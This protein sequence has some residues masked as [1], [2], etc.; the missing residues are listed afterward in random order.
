MQ[1]TCPA[2]VALIEEPAAYRTHRSQPSPAW[3]GH[4]GW[5]HGSTGAPK[6]SGPKG[7]E[8]GPGRPC[9]TAMRDQ[10]DNKA[11]PKPPNLARWPGADSDD[12]NAEWC[13]RRQITKSSRI[14]PM[15]P[16]GPLRSS[17]APG[18]RGPAG[19]SRFLGSGGDHP[20]SSGRAACLPWPSGT[21]S[22]ATR[23]GYRRPRR[24]G[25]SWGR[26]LRL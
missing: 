5:D 9:A 18:A 16:A 14:N 7:I 25:G 2:S 12:H 13:E 23:A 15:R 1:P 17:A 11:M 8:P 6:T 21:R 20:G 10:A 4:L 3:P 22:W 19:G 24:P 26:W